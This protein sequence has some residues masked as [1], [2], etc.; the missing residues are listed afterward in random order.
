M[1]DGSKWKLEDKLTIKLDLRKE[2]EK[3]KIVFFKND[4]KEW[5]DELDKKKIWYPAITVG[6]NKKENRE[7]Y[8]LTFE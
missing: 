4:K 7:E 2:N 3:G 6:G 1:H 8:I 5:D